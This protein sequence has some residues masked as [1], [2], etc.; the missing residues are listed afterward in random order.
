MFNRSITTLNINSDIKAKLLRISICNINDLK[1]FTP[2]ELA[3]EINIPINLAESIFEQIEYSHIKPI[4]G[5]ELY[6]NELKKINSIQSFCK[7]LDNLLEGVTVNGIPLGKI[8]E[9]CGPPGI[10]KTQLGIQLSINV[11]IPKLCKGVEGKAIFIDTE[12]SFMIERVVQ[13]ANSTINYIKEAFPNYNNDSFNLNSILS[14]IQY[15]RVHDFQ[16]Q[17][18]LINLLENYVTNDPSIKVIVIDS[19]AF[20]FRQ[21][22]SSMSLRTQI[23][24]NIAQ[25]LMKI[26]DK[27]NVAV[28]IMNQMT[29]KFQKIN[30][31]S[32]I[33]EES[34]LIPALG[35]SWGH[36]STNRFILSTT[37]NQTVRK[38]FLQKSPNNKQGVAY[39]QITNDGLR[40]I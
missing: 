27:Y 20:H 19:I 28:V 39:Y 4:S 40:D 12:G 6:T 22:F 13:I 14:N 30:E 38:I 17:I 35:E 29:M 16:E 18:A 2:K 34:S 37:D 8:T 11:Q 32:L 9:F 26:A 23:L 3:K 31:G 7:A 1:Y 36:A 33:K 10:G 5:L 25:I 21:T 15:F 24:N